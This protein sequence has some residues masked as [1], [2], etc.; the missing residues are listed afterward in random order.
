MQIQPKYEE[1]IRFCLVGGLCTA[2]DAVLFYLVRMIAPYHV[3]L[4]C[5]YLTG[6]VVNYFLTVMWTFRTRPTKKNAAGVILAHLFNLFAV[7]MG[8][9]FLF[10]SVLSLND[11][12]AFIPTLCIS[13]LTNFVIIKFLIAKLSD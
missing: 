1:F 10:V 6:L 8:L 7:R 11:R 4:V 3:A 12:I 9:M 5:G 2:I 13:V